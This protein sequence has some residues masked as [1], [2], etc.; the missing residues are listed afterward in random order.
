MRSF[1]CALFYL[2]Y[3]K[4]PVILAISIAILTLIWSIIDI[5]IFQETSA[6]YSYLGY[7]YDYT[8][9]GI[10]GLDSAFLALVI[11]WGIG[12]V[13]TCATWFFSALTISTNIVKT[14][15]L[16]EM[17]NKLDQN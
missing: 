4:L 9:Y 17:N 15:I 2:L 11:W 10:M 12:A 1:C 13:L 6:G 14:D 8:Y 16:L 7:Y 5:I 3:K